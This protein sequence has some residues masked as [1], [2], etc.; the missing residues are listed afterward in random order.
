MVKLRPAR[1]TSQRELSCVLIEF[2][3]LSF[4]VLIEFPHGRKDAAP[5]IGERAEVFLLRFLD[6]AARPTTEIW[7]AAQEEGIGL[8]TL[9][10]AA[11]HL[12]IRS[13][14]IWNGKQ[15]LTYW[16]LDGQKFPDSIPPEFRP[17]DIS[18]LFAEE[19]AKYPGD[20]LDDDD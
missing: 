17:D 15:Q 7:E 13:Q 1:A 3:P 12:Q 18:D 2:P 8:R 20:P 9:Q 10:R 14:R 11:R 5:G 6:E 19:R 4:P 16:L